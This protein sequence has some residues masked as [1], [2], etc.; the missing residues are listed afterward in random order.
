V[1]DWNSATGKLR[2]IRTVN[3]NFGLVGANGLFAV[4]GT[5][6]PGVGVISGITNAEVASGS[7]QILYV[8]NRRPIARAMNQTESLTIV[9]EF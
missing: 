4:G 6:T 7:G 2:V 8:E 1:V 3:E 5:V 9:C